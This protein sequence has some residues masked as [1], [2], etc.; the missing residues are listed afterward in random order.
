MKKILLVLLIVALL[1]VLSGCSTVGGLFAQPTPVPESTPEP[2]PQPTPVPT[3]TPQ[4]TPVPVVA[5]K[6]YEYEKLSNRSLAVAFSYPTHWINEPGKNTISYYEP[7]ESNDVP[8]RMAVAVKRASKATQEDVKKQ[9]SSL[10]DSISQQYD[11]YQVTGTTR[12]AKLIRQTALALNYEAEKDEIAIKG[13]IVMT[14]IKDTKR[15]YAIHFCA[16][17]E[18]YDD[19]ETVRKKLI[20]SVRTAA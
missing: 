16:P 11:S 7:V 12:N 19:F 3:P 8:A 17:A 18:D 2:T 4:P 13:T 1:P 20:N 5:Y 15:I 6:D 9:I 14:F 10:S